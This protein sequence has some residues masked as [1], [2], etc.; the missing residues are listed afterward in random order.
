[1]DDDGVGGEQR[2]KDDGGKTGDDVQKVGEKAV[3][4]SINETK[5]EDDDDSEGCLKRCSNREK[6]E[7]IF[8][9]IR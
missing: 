2:D 7:S 6:V 5:E 8:I 3:G 4:E 9:G 1:M